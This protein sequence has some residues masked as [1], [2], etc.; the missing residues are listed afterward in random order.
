LANSRRRER[1]LARRRYER[2]RMREQE[3]RARRRRRNTVVGAALGTAAVI[4]LIAFAAVELTSGSGHKATV[5]P[6]ASLTP[7]LPP[8]PTPT[9]TTPPPPPPKHCAAI[10]PNPPDKA[11]PKVPPVTGKAPT[12][13]VIKDLKKGK[14]KAAKSGSKLEVNYVGVACS[15]GKAFD[16]SYPRHQTFPFTLGQG[17]VI[18]G[19]DRG[20][21]GMRQGGRRELIIPASL[22]YGTSGQQGIRPN[23]TL[24]FVVDLVKVS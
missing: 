7:T 6:Q 13:L 9:V 22:A 8:T 19:W 21:V 4:G 17:A 16:A 1:E 14:G 5:T 10:K 3:A 12:H 2:R 20:L 11:D 23:E 15:T 18:Q 24:I